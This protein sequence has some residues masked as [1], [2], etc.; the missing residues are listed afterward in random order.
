MLAKFSTITGLAC[1]I[2]GSLCLLRRAFLAF[3]NGSFQKRSTSPPTEEISAVRRGRGDKIVSDN[4]K[5]ISTS[6][7]GR[8]VNFQ[9]PPWGGMDV[10]WNDP[11]QSFDVIRH[12]QG[13]SPKW[14]IRYRGARLIRNRSFALLKVAWHLTC[15]KQGAPSAG[16]KFVHNVKSPA[17]ITGLAQ[18]QSR[19]K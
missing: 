19:K 12:K 5:C 10:F 7:G 6:E 13:D 14:E 15:L 1:L 11:M 2:P 3:N 17:W 16:L 4:S 9:F 8:G 18:T